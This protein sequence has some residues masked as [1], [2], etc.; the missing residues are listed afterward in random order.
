MERWA[1]KTAIVTGA[2][3]GIG[4]IVAVKL[5]DHGMKVVGLARRKEMVDALNKK[6]SNKGGKIYGIKV[7]LSKEE[8]ILKAFEWSK[9]NVGPVS[10]LINNAGVCIQAGLTNG[11]T[12]YWKEMIDV[13]LMS[14]CIGTREACQQMKQHK[15]DGHIVHINSIL[16]HKIPGS[17]FFAM[18]TA[19]KW[20]ITALTEALRVELTSMNSKIKISDVSPGVVQTDMVTSQ[21]GVVRDLYR[22]STALDPND[23]ADAVIYVVGTPPTV[24]VHELIIKPL[25][26]TF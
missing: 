26:E 24:Q 22:S 17:P 1:G 8:D 4:A 19:T 16:G 11:A 6:L 14:L 15:I 13:N 5:A 7:D 3:A 18:Y 21:T 12:K 10:I 23:V 9:D 25:N 20:G 2:S